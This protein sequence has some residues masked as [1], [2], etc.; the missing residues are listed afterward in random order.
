M[1]LSPLLMFGLCFVLFV[2]LPQVSAFGHSVVGKRHFPTTFRIDDPSPSDEFS[3]LGE[4]RN[5]RDETG[6]LQTETALGADYAKLI[7]NDL[8]VA[9]SD[10]YQ[11]RHAQGV[12][13]SGFGNLE[14]SAKYQF[15]TSEAHET[16]LAFGIADEIGDTGNRKVS[17]TFSTIS[18]A[19]LFGKGFGDLADQGSLLRPFAVTGLVA[20]NM[21][22]R[23]QTGSVNSDTGDL[24]IMRNPTTL[25][26]GVS[27]QYSLLYLQSFVRD[28]GLPR[29]LDRLVLVVDTSMETCLNRGCDGRTTG[30]ASPGVVWVGKGMEIGI[31]AEVPLNANSGKGIGAL[32]LFH[33]FLDDLFPHSL[34]RP[35]FK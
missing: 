8:G 22:T 25:S 6:A 5:V 23:A 13:V 30:T 12:T 4:R 21:P 35:L 33:V 7:T 19:L 14:V 26:W 32:V 1:N 27:L 16:I 29:P 10:R 3:M 9:I 34:G 17:D 28:A 24:D 11:S 15:Y 18:P 2:L 20:A 31:A